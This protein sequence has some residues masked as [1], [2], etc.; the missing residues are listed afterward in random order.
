MTDLPGNTVV[1]LDGTDP[2]EQADGRDLV[3][4]DG[5]ER[6]RLIASQLTC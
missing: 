6:G 3:L 1:H 4:I 2:A 5:G